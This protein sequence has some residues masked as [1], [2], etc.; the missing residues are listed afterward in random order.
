MRIDQASASARSASRMAFAAVSRADRARI[1]API[2]RPWKADWRDLE[3][4]ADD[5]SAR[6]RTAQRH[7][8]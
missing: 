5:F 6:C 2:N 4:M 3:P 8:N 1:F 7:Q